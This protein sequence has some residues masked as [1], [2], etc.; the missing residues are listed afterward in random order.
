MNMNGSNKTKVT[1]LFRLG[2]ANLSCLQRDTATKIQEQR[3]YSICQ[4]DCIQATN[5][6]KFVPGS[7]QIKLPVPGLVND[8]TALPPG[9]TN[10]SNAPLSGTGNWSNLRH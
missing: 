3:S 2:N 6:Q 1:Y 4:S 8:Q 9:R 7:N 10:L 5:M